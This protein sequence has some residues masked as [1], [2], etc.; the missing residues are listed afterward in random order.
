MKLLQ[1][2]HTSVAKCCFLLSFIATRITGF[3]IGYSSL[4]GNQRSSQP[5]RRQPR[6]SKDALFRDDDDGT[7]P[8]I[9]PFL[10]LAME[11]SLVKIQILMATTTETANPKSYYGLSSW[12]KLWKDCCELVQVD[13]S[14]VP[15][16]GLGLLANTNLEEGTVVSFYPVHGIGMDHTSTGGTTAAIASTNDV[17]QD[18]FDTQQDQDGRNYRQCLLRPL[19]G[20]ST[21]IRG[22]E[23]LF[24]DVN[25]HRSVHP[26]WTSHCVNDG[27]TI[28][29]QPQ[30]YQEEQVLT[31]YEQSLQK[32]N[33]VQIPFG[34][35]PLMA[36]VTT[37]AVDAGEELF[38]CYGAAYWLPVV[39]DPNHVPKLLA[40]PGILKSI[41]HSACLT[42]ESIQKVSAR[43]DKEWAGI[44]ESFLA[45]F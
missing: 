7:S 25:P 19:T 21:T 16:A 32:Q 27:A 13:Q 2:R 34:P 30:G 10:A 14:T 23:K 4:L 26:G 3:L 22:K 18:F 33:C 41:D 5:S 39:G 9:D 17:D 24:I 42:R 36:T 35:V 15:N 20:Y 11:E 38:T 37:R 28:L 12:K 43:Y 1:Q 40:S 6:F 31:Y 29:P 45:A 8:R 44:E